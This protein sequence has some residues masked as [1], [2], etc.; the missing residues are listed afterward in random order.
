MGRRWVCRLTEIWRWRAS[1]VT[2]VAGLESLA[3]KT[4][5]TRSHVG[6]NGQIH[7]SLH[8]TELANRD[9][10]IIVLIR[11]QGLRTTHT[12]VPDGASHIGDEEWTA[13]VKRCVGEGITIHNTAG[14][15]HV[16]GRT[17]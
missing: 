10:D 13:L 11:P 12:Y 6:T 15:P 14:H 3:M 1:L 9:V 7:L 5:H 4:V 17:S 8:A 16:A 2:G